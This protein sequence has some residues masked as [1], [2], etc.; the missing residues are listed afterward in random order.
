MRGPGLRL[1]YDVRRLWRCPVCGYERRAPAMEV[2]V[3][4]HCNH[5][6]PWMKLVEPKRQVR[7]PARPHDPYIEV[8]SPPDEPEPQPAEIPETEPSGP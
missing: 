1:K 8:A 5:E 3:R 7:P 2:V 6:E 4:C